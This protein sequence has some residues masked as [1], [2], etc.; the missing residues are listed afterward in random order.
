MGF[1]GTKGYALLVLAVIVAVASWGC[2]GS[3]HHSGASGTTN[4]GGTVTPQPGPKVVSATFEDV[5]KDETVSK[6]DFVKVKFDSDIGIKVSAGA[7]NAF[8][9]GVKNDNLGS[10]AIITQNGKK[11]EAVIVLGDKPKLRISG[12]YSNS[13]GESGEPSGLDVVKDSKAIVGTNGSYAEP[14]ALVDLEGP[15]TEQFTASGKLN[16]P[17]GIHTA[18]LLLDGR[19]LVTGGVTGGSK[20]KFV[21]VS[22]VFDAVTGTFKKTS[23]KSLGGSKYGYMWDAKGKFP[24]SSLT[25]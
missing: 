24:R 15:F 19:V 8:Q 17:R 18:T 21:T 10:G 1:F 6:G 4:P 20:A 5:D 23:D 16:V 12:K 3:S 25:T 14:N 13:G 9:L 11:N 7:E 2:G 22:E